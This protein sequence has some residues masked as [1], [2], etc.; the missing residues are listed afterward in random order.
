MAPSVVIID[1]SDF[2]VNQLGTFFEHQL[3]FT[4]A[5][6]GNDGTDAVD[7]YKKFKPDLLTLDITMPN[8]DG[9]QTIDEILGEF[10]DAKILMI[11]AV[12][13]GGMLDC[14]SAGA[15]DFIEKP[16]KFNDPAFVAEFKLVVAKIL[17][18]KS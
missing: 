15:A 12:S 16:L 5:G 2:I 11:S 6:V 17:G 8:M 1:D 9:Q 4:I 7:L 13:G 14:I 10:P 18:Q 3:G